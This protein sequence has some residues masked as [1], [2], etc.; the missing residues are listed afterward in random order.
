V[1]ALV[2][3]PS[4]ISVGDAVRT[5]EQYAA[6][7][8]PRVGLTN[9]SDLSFRTGAEAFDDDLPERAPR[10]L[11]SGIDAIDEIAPLAEGGTNLIIDSGDSA[12]AFDALVGRISPGPVISATS[13]TPDFEVGYGIRY[14]ANDEALLAR[15]TARRWTRRV[16][17][18]D[19]TLVLEGDE[20]LDLDHWTA[21]I[22]GAT[23]FARMVVD[24]A[25]GAIAETLDIGTVDTQLYLRG[26]GTIDFRRS[27]SR[28]A[29]DDSKWPEQ[30][31]RA[32]E[33]EDRSAL[34]GDQELDDQE[35]KLLDIIRRV[36]A[37]T[38][39]GN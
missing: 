26:D 25:L 27:H 24:D 8:A 1:Q 14:E 2:F 13:R 22:G 11:A 23:V 28:L 33:I 18:D 35:R 34:F 12:A 38:L 20:D 37:A 4:P 7:P 30:F 5:D 32:Q 19:V 17:G 15:E 6:W 36:D 9:V 39:D 16:D 31:H 3:D 10:L 29:D 21:D